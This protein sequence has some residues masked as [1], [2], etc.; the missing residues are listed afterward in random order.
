MHYIYYFILFVAIATGYVKS[1]M[2]MQ[3]TQ[4]VSIMKKNEIKLKERKQTLWADFYEVLS[5][6]NR[7]GNTQYG[8]DLN[9]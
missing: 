9:E 4:F 2:R 8:R 1:D 5:V 7:H 3:N 6:I